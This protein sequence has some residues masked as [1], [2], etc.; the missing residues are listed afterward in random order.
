MLEGGWVYFYLA[1]SLRALPSLV[2]KKR[3]VN[4]QVFVCV[5]V[6]ERFG[7]SGS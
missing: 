6:F 2:V 1:A 3:V 5:F 7:R 4:V